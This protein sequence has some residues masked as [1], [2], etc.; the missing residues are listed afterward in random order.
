M[1]HYHSRPRI[2]KNRKIDINNNSGSTIVA[3]LM[4]L[5]IMSI[6]IFSLTESMNSSQKTVRLVK[7]NIYADS[8]AE[9][10]RQA[11]S[12]EEVCT[13]N[14]QNVDVSVVDANNF[15]NITALDQHLKTP[16]SVNRI[17]EKDQ[18]VGSNTL[19]YTGMRLK[20]SP[21]NNA[22]LYVDF[23]KR[24][25]YLG[26]KAL[27]RT[28]K[29]KY[30]LAG[31]LISSCV[32]EGDTLIVT[33]C[34]MIDGVLNG[35][36]CENPYIPMNGVNPGSFDSAGNITAPNL[37]QATQSA[38]FVSDISA[39]AG[40]SVLAD[41]TLLVAG[42]NSS[43]ITA[44]RTE[45]RGTSA[46][47]IST[48]FHHEGTISIS[49]QICDGAGANCINSWAARVC[50]GGPEMFVQSINADGSLNCGAVYQ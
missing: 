9:Q 34:D 37:A 12:S 33:G 41:A 6:S 48:R 27:V 44:N 46:A 13:H 15:I 5:S 28:F 40:G 42:L 11:L 18:I 20:N 30:Y 26:T 43:T 16:H 31:N 50:P 38:T 4:G 36:V 29:L 7:Q 35:L 8:I 45:G 3:V 49:G 39:G 17:F 1:L 2:F 10:F 25:G 14:F 32:V 23:E 21:P 47:A 22:I 19:I 24:G